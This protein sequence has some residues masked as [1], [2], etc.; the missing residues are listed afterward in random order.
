MGRSTPRSFALPAAALVLGEPEIAPGSIQGKLDLASAFANATR[1]E[2]EVGFGKG[3]FLIAA[4]TARPDTAFLGIERAA[5]YVRLVRH[6]VLQAL[7]ANVKLLRADAADVFRRLMPADAVDEIHVLFPDPWP[8][9]RHR[10]RRM[11]TPGLVA[12]LGRA[13]KPG[14]FLNIVTD[15]TDYAEVIPRCDAEA[16][17]LVRSDIERIGGDIAAMT[18]FAT[19]LASRGARFHVFTWRRQ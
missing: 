13:L 3:R 7:L 16:T 6:R 1:I 10:H 17:M 2:V 18:H 9:Q 11:V 4:A 12:D 14:G 15:H 8:K 19:R 5:P